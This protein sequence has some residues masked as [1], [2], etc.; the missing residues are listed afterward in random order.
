MTEQKKWVPTMNQV[1]KIFAVELGAK[2][3]MVSGIG[4][5]VAAF[6][7]MGADLTWLSTP[8]TVPTWL[9]LMAVLFLAGGR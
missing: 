8:V 6:R 2:F 9:A 4:I 5:A 7:Y 1:A 3:G